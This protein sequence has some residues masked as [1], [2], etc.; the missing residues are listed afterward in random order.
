M[1]WLK[2]TEPT[3]ADIAYAAGFFDGEGTIDIR[4]R[5][6]HGG[7]YERYELRLSLGQMD[8]RPLLR[9]AE[10]FGGSVQKQNA[11][12]H[13]WVCTGPGAR[14]FLIA[15]R[16]HLI[17]KDGQADTALEFCAT[18][19]G[20]RG[21]SVKGRRGFAKHGNGVIAERHR[22]FLEVRAIRQR[23]GVRPR[24]RDTVLPPSAVQG[25]SL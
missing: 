24:H 17:V 7:K 9:L 25:A 12:L 4:R 3:A 22:C 11:K 1:K 15:V 14:D 16:P 6:T 10:L 20:V 23:A 18:F 5:R 13:S 21:C 19:N 2:R 8:I